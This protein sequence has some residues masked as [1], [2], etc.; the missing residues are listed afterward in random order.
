MPASTLAALR[1]RRKSVWGMRPL[2][3]AV[4]GV[5]QSLIGSDQF[6][7]ERQRRLKNQQRRASA[8]VKVTSG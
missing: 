1:T 6:S 3:H 2:W 7:D 5:Q 4:P 8:L